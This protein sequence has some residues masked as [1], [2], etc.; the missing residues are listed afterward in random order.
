MVAGL[1]FLALAF[2]A[3]GQAGA[4]RNS[5][6]SGADAAA[7]AAAQETRDR[8]A[9]DLLANF[10]TPGFL[11]D[12]FNGEPVGPV[13]GCAAALR[14]ADKNGMDVV[15]PDGCRGL[16]DG[17]WGITVDVISQESMGQSILPDTEDKKAEATA[18]AVIVPR[19][20]FKPAEED[21]KPEEEDPEPGG[22]GE[23]GGEEATPLPGELRCD[24]RG[25]LDLDPENLVLPD[26]S[27]L[28]SVRLAED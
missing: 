6:Q 9:E 26:M 25:L 27:V 1:L 22:G 5:A 19:C 14:L 16:N 24:G 20:E 28:F 21:G 8:F 7:L 10:F 12:V 11:E 17:R 2:F 18:T 3:V 15:T 4:T 23:D 13:L